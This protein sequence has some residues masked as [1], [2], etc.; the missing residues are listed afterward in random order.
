MQ[1]YK[2]LKEIENKAK[3]KCLTCEFEIVLCL[4]DHASMSA[5]ELF[6]RSRYSSTAFYSTLK[7][8]AQAGLIV[9]VTDSVDRRS[10]TYCLSQHVRDVMNCCTGLDLEK[11]N[12]SAT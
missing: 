9:G 6:R 7:R 5:G 11:D 2:V 8:L 12:P 10:N 3:V 1:L 4:Y